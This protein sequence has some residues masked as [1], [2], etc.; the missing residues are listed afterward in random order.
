MFLAAPAAAQWTGSVGLLSDYRYRGISR[1]DRQPVVQATIAYD[2]SSGLFAGAQGSSMRLSHRGEEIGFELLAYTGYARHFGNRGAWEVGLLRYEYPESARARTYA[3][4][5]TFVG[6][7]Y[8]G[9][10]LRAFY[11]PDYVAIR[12][13]SVYLQGAYVHPVDDDTQ[14][15]GQIGVLKLAGRDTSQ[16][17]ASAPRRSDLRIG[18]LRTWRDLQFDASIVASDFPDTACPRG[19]RLCKWGL[20]L[21]VSYLFFP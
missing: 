2:H 16:T 10:S 20:V 17:L 13:R 21:G 1:S 6:A 4:N 19:E 3:Y 15:Y 12:S 5:E 7:S 8:G 11:S 14:V 9:F 18:V